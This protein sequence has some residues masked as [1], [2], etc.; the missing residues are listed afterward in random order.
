MLKKN[1]IDISGYQP[2]PRNVNLCTQVLK[3]SLSFTYTQSLFPKGIQ[4]LMGIWN[5]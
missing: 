2:K 3:S 1:E 4:S 5:F